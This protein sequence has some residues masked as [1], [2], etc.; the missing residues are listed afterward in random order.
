MWWRKLLASVMLGIDF[1]EVL[2]TDRERVIHDGLAFGLK[3]LL[4]VREE[5]SETVDACSPGRRKVA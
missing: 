1:G 5:V 2:L 3:F 4:D